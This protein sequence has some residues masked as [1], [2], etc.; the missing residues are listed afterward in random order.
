MKVLIIGGGC[1]PQGHLSTITPA[2]VWMLWHQEWTVTQGRKDE[3]TNCDGPYTKIVLT[4]PNESLV[5]VG[6]RLPWKTSHTGLR[7]SILA[8]ESLVFV[9]FEISMGSIVRAVAR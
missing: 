3:S 2:A 1:T 5:F 6:L 9:G 4:Q 8:N 7:W